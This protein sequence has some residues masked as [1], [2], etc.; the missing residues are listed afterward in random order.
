[1]T[2]FILYIIGI[3]LDTRVIKR[4]A[5]FSP[6]I[7]AFFLIAGSIVAIS[8]ILI[9]P[10]YLAKSIV[11][12][13]IFASFIGIATLSLII[14]VTVLDV[15]NIIYPSVWIMIVGGFVVLFFAIRQI[16]K[17]LKPP[18]FL[19]KVKPMEDQKGILQMLIKPQRITEEEITFHK[20][21]KICLVCKTKVS[22]VIFLCPSCAALYCI[23]C[24]EALSN[25]ENHCWV[26]EAAIDETKAVKLP[27]KEL[28]LI[29]LEPL[30]DHKGVKKKPEEE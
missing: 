24:S 10:K 13:I 26:C 16:I 27:E 5:L 9:N 18:V 28:E 21:Q 4:L 15:G 30:M 29:P 25:L 20:E 8:P 7:P 14:F 19:E 12:W 6:T 11:L 23:K 3:I 17:I 22:R 2:G 1:M